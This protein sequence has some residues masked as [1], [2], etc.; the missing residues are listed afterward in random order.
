MVKDYGL[1]FQKKINA[2][3]G[4][5]VVHFTINDVSGF[6]HVEME[7]YGPSFKR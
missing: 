5:M 6:V 1:T 3:P 4:S 7:S 2:F